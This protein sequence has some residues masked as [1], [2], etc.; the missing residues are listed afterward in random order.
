MAEISVKGIPS[1]FDEED[2]DLLVLAITGAVSK[3]TELDIS[4]NEI[5]VFFPPDLR[6]RKC[7]EPI[8]INVDHLFSGERRKK[9]KPVVIAKVANEVAKKVADKFP[10]RKIECT[11]N[12]F[13]ETVYGVVVRGPADSF[14]EAS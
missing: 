8:T 11:V 6:V 4:P 3:I 12:P 7:D 13:G 10:L 5:S 14:R 9:R 1:Y 2:L